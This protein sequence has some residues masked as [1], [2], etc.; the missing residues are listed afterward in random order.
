M[1]SAVILITV[2]PYS[3]SA[4]A[5]TIALVAPWQLSFKALG[6][7]MVGAMAAGTVPAW[8]AAHHAPL[9]ALQDG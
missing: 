9:A 5:V 4:E 2:S 8:V 7:S 3:L 6:F 1:L